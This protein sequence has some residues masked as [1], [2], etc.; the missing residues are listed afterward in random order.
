[1]VFAF[2]FDQESWETEQRWSENMKSGDVTSEQELKAYGGAFDFQGQGDST[3]KYFSTG[4]M[5]PADTPRLAADVRLLVSPTAVDD[6][7]SCNVAPVGWPTSTA[8]ITSLLEVFEPLNLEWDLT[9][10]MGMAYLK[11]N[12]AAKLDTGLPM[13]PGYGY[14][15]SA[16]VQIKPAYS[17]DSD[18]VYT[19]TSWSRTISSKTTVRYKLPTGQGHLFRVTYNINMDDSIYPSV[20]TNTF[21][22][23]DL[24][25]SYSACLGFLA[26]GLSLIIFM[27]SVSVVVK[28]QLEA[29]AD[30]QLRTMKAINVSEE[31]LVALIDYVGTS[32]NTADH[33]SMQ[34][35]FRDANRTGSS[36]HEIY[37][38]LSAKVGK[39]NLVLCQ[40]MFQ[41]SKSVDVEVKEKEV[42][43]LS[44][45]KLE[46]RRGPQCNY[47]ELWTRFWDILQDV[48]MYPVLYKILKKEFVDQYRQKHKEESELG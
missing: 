4:A 1:M 6:I 38:E 44:E 19:L 20:V 9:A 7:L 14:V 11:D 27:N 36:P 41:V 33:A 46:R 17:K 25:V 18:D 23:M 2:N 10:V 13:V 35:V 45:Y 48:H 37:E 3:G 26:L 34:Q 21:S 24:I 42:E 28:E 29:A 5:I 43:L 16:T 15:L 22:Y 8:G 47:E 31:Y 30:R 39:T 12:E 40:V 32:V